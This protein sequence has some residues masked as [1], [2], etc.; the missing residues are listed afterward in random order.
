MGESCVKRQ[1][2]DTISEIN[3]TDIHGQRILIVRFC[4]W[5]TTSRIYILFY[6][7]FTFFGEKY[8]A[9]IFDKAL[10]LGETKSVMANLQL[11]LTL[12]NISKYAMMDQN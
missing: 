2:E 3:T 10:K 11:K 7:V 8:I 12:Q 4:F 5:K 6:H 1:K 9:Y